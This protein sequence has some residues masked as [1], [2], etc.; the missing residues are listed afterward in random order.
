M[1]EFRRSRFE[2]VENRH[3][4]ARIQ[5][6]HRSAEA[7]ASCNVTKMVEIGTKCPKWYKLV[8]NV[9]NGTLGR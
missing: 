3:W 4:G 2:N 1:A 8:Q 7:N 9:Q 6:G 5:T